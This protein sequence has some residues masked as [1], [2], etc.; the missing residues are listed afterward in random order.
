M[1]IGIALSNT[2]TAPYVDN[3]S[4]AQVSGQ[5]LGSWALWKIKTVAVDTAGY[6]MPD[7]DFKFTPSLR[8]LAIF[9]AGLGLR[10]VAANS[11]IGMV[12]QWG[13]TLGAMACDMRLGGIR[14]E[15]PQ[16][17][18]DVQKQS[19]ENPEHR[20]LDN[21]PT[22][23]I[24]KPQSPPQTPPANGS[25]TLDQALADTRTGEGTPVFIETR[26]T[27]DGRCCRLVW[28]ESGDQQPIPDILR[29]L[30]ATDKALL[31]NLPSLLTEQ[32]FAPEKSWA[33]GGHR[34]A[35][36]SFYQ[37]LVTR[38][39]AINIKHPL[40]WLRDFMAAF[41]RQRPEVLDGH[42]LLNKILAYAAMDKQCNRAMQ[43]LTGFKLFNPESDAAQVLIPQSSPPNKDFRKCI[44]LLES[45]ENWQ[46]N[47]TQ[48][49]VFVN[50]GFGSAGKLLTGFS[51]LSLFGSGMGGA[52]YKT[53]CAA[54]DAAIDASTCYSNPLSKACD[55][56]TGYHLVKGG[57]CDNFCIKVD[58]ADSN[59]EYSYDVPIEKGTP[60]ASQFD[61]DLAQEL[62][63]ERCFNAGSNIEDLFVIDKGVKDYNCTV[64]DRNRLPVSGQDCLYQYAVKEC[65]LLKDS[66]NV[67]ARFCALC[68]ASY[69][70]SLQCNPRYVTISTITY[71]R[72]SVSL[73]TICE[74]QNAIVSSK[75][76]QSI[77]KNYCINNMKS[78][79]LYTQQTGDQTWWWK[80]GP[81][82]CLRA[83]KA[84]TGVFDLYEANINYRC[85]AP[86]GGY[87]SA[88]Y[89]LS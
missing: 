9:G 32:S 18:P 28:A 13:A 38:G 6:L 1:G 31:D 68:D 12:G 36:E 30:T 46:T 19:V 55:K 60:D 33:G 69:H 63:F 51:L 17:S 88:K 70:Q 66:G 20:L 40:V 81:D 72:N 8:G 71:N 7:V 47:T 21:A 62:G 49:A 82:R 16:V 78:L 22:P 52:T 42:D 2:H 80:L 58:S 76:Y 5:R 23:E 11:A 41:K 35:C 56:S 61:P 57:L 50:G 75:A 43:L 15:Q 44:A 54:S 29:A 73:E 77:C 45:V 24:N 10:V 37:N 27:E 83:K 34:E 85:K 48:Q 86:E 39:A 79:P 53:Y 4:D 65:S 64:G 67:A 3:A 87:S 89:R 74:Y 25:L 59:Y 14:E 84:I 26:T